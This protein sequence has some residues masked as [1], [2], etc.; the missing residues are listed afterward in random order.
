MN[1]FQQDEI[2]QKYSIKWMKIHMVR[3]TWKELNISKI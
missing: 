2:K 3:T 1:D